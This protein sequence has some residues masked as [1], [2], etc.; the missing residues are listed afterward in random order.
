MEEHREQNK[1]LDQA[2]C[3]IGFYD[4][5]ELEEIQSLQDMFS[6]A[7]G[8]ASLI[9]LPDGTPITQ[10]SNFCRLCKDIIRST[11]IGCGNCQKSDLHIGRHNPQGPIVQKCLSGGLWDAGASITIGNKHL[12][13]WL[14]GQVRNEEVNEDQ[15]MQYAIEIGA[16]SEDFRMAL[17]EVPVMSLDKFNKIAK[18]LFAFANELSQKAFTNFQL[19][20]RIS[21]LEEAEENIRLR[22]SFLSAIIENQPGLLW[23]KDHKG[24]FQAV[25][26]KF[27]L[28]CGIDNPE[29]LV[30]KT[31]FDVWPHKQASQYVADDNEILESGEPR[32]IEELISVKGKNY[33]HETYKS[34]V[35]N[36]KGEI[37]GST[38]FSRDITQRKKA[39]KELQRIQ[40]RNLALLNANPDLMFLLDENGVFIDYSEGVDNELYTAP[41]SFLC[42]SVDDVL[43]PEIASLTKSHLNRLF[44]T[45]QMQIYEYQLSIDQ[46]IRYFDCRL[47]LCGKHQGLSIVREITDRKKSDI[48]LQEKNEEI[49]SQNE[50]YLQINE[51]L[52]QTNDEL[53][54][55]KQ[56]A[57][58]S[59][60]LKTAF[61][62]NLSHEIRTPMNAILGFSDLLTKNFNNK[63]KL[64]KYAHIINQRSNDLL[65]IIND[66]LEIAKI[67]SGQLPLNYEKFQ[68]SDLFEELTVMFNEYQTRNGKQNIMFNMQ[69]FCNPFESTIVTDKGKLKQI[70]INLISNAFKFTHEGKIE[71]GCKLENNRVHFFVSDTGMGIPKDKQDIIFDRFTQ[72]KQNLNLN[73]G[74]TGLGLSIVKGIVK[75]LEGEITLKSEPGK[76][77]AFT[78]TIPVKAD[79]AESFEKPVIHAAKDYNFSNKTVL[80]IEDDL[81]NA[82]FLKDLLSDKGFTIF[83]AGFGKEGVKI[84]LENTV[85]II[86]MDIR[87]PDIDGYEATRQIKLQKPEI[88]II[89]QTAYASHDERKKAKDEGCND[90]ISKPIKKDLLLEMIR[91]QLAKND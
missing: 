23:L 52:K 70:F 11:K 83:Q 49:E 55:A 27:S 59:D 48:L 90:Y 20:L 81:Y 17:K 88:K 10:S 12:A 14:I 80:I 13:N 9:T 50:E 40:E 39:E 43:P 26:K 82:E 76:G 46:Q 38:G 67:E 37:I 77:S 51:E 84:A 30:G 78:F 61:L 3:N 31:D 8:V 1:T 21:E 28:S 87:L 69:V 66:I 53:Y 7:T 15:I 71:G 5:F 42:K 25:N 91:K 62:Q 74:G 75:L 29:L 86:L 32:M 36:K 64:E 79:F 58:E 4:I 35:R 63:E 54:K 65:E 45:G 2:L 24:R 18:M 57:E 47:V 41:E 89:A 22:K 73:I 56:H 33:W 16:N 68:L 85:D 44:E 60:R 72:L 34:P 19:K 6:D